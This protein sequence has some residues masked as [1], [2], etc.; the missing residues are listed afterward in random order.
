MDTSTRSSCSSALSNAVANDA[1]QE[2]RRIQALLASR[3]VQ[4]RKHEE[5]R[6]VTST[7]RDLSPPRHSTP[8]R[9]RPAVV[10]PRQT[11]ASSRRAAASASTSVLS[12]A[13]SNQRPRTASANN[14][15]RLQVKIQA[16]L[17]SSKE[18]QALL[19]RQYDLLEEANRQL[20]T[21]SLQQERQRL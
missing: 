3:G 4:Q 16:T 21:I 1:A 13:S 18:M 14:A 2:L 8:Q 15:R 17:R 11:T 19:S 10:P 5:A 7:R 12:G 9:L 6:E 20:K